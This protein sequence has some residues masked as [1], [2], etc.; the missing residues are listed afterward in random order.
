MLDDR[1]RMTTPAN[2]LP[3]RVR[4]RPIAWVPGELL[5]AVDVSL[6]PDTDPRGVLAAVRKQVTAVLGDDIP[7]E[8]PESES[9]VVLLLP[10]AEGNRNLLFASIKLVSTEPRVMRL[11]IERINRLADS[12]LLD[13]VVLVAATPNWF[14]AAQDCCG[15]SPASQPVPTE[16]FG[17]RVRYA[18]QIE[19]LDRVR[20]AS[21]TVREG[22]RGVQV[23]V[24]DTAPDT[25]DVD[26]ALEH[27][28]DNRQLR[29]LVDRLISPIGRFPP[30]PLETARERAM[31]RLEQHGGFKPIEPAHPFDIRDH[32]L[33]V[34]GVVH[35][36]APWAELRLIRVLNNYGMG[37]LE[38]VLISLVGLMQTR[39]EIPLVINLS[40]GMLPA[41]EQLTS[42]WFGL[43]VEGL[44]GCPEDASLQFVDGATRSASEL[45]QMIAADAPE[46]NLAVTA[47]HAPVVRLM[48]G[49]QANN[50]LV[51]AAAGN[52]SA[53]R[54]VNRRP[55]WNPRIPA[56]YDT[57]LGVAADTVRPEVPARYSNR[58]EAPT[59]SVRD[60]VST[61]GGG[62]GSDGVSP[63][64]GVIGV[65]SAE[66]FP[67]LLPPEPPRLNAT[68]WAEW[69]GTSFAT[70]IMSGIAANLWTTAPARTAAQ[71]LDE[72]NKI[73][74]AGRPNIA[75]LEVPGVPV[76]LTWLP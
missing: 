49:L 53:F 18:P 37:S 21:K 2:P 26:W 74:H 16:P 19:A 23:A 40:L 70:P 73:A 71:V 7:V 1:S 3:R 51:V 72:I 22:Q 24:L 75:G 55:R 44:P 8:T 50:C 47:L 64:A 52:D 69:S 30:S 9:E 11:A 58:G 66:E 15:G 76:R 33:F 36:V 14:S 31:Q 13:N 62:L 32:G 4:V 59:E 68:G 45:R 6:P 35:S 10:A 67:P 27:F 41:L 38:S 25:A 48:A 17:D 28:P 60:A 63:I 61:L 56:L 12:P 43:S 42:I 39:G 57:T 65:Y 29:E 46:I 5:V 20:D 34:A 54:G